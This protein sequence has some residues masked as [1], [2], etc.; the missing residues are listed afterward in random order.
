[1][2]KYYLLLK[3]ILEFGELQENKKGDNIGLLNQ[4]LVRL[5]EQSVERYGAASVGWRD[6]ID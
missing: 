1:M 3:N 6:G 2:N 5:Y 4:R